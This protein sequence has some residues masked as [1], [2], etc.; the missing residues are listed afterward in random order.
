[1]SFLWP[2]GL[3]FLALI[4]GI[5]L[6]YF[7]RL[8][9][10][11]RV[12]SSTFL[13]KKA[14]D[15]YRVN[16]P[17]QKFQNHLMLWLQLIAVLLLSVAASR[18]YAERR[19]RT[20]GVHIV[21]L[22]H[23]ASM[24]VREEGGVTRL[25]LA[26]SF[27]RDMIGGLRSGERMMVIGFSDRPF[28]AAPLTSDRAV[29]IRGTN[30]VEPTTRP[31]RI[32]EAWHTALSV[33]R[34][35]DLSDIYLLSDGGFRVLPQLTQAHANV[36]YIPF[37]KSWDNVGIVHVET[38]ESEDSERRIEIFARTVNRR[39]QPARTTVEL[40]FGDRLVDAQTIEIPA[41][42]ERGVVFERPAQEEGMAEIRL[43][44]GGAFA[45][46]DRAWIPLGGSDLVRVVLVGEENVFLKQAL[47]MIPRLE[48]TVVAP[49]DFAK[50]RSK[51]G[52]SDLIV[53]DG[54]DAG[55]LER[56]TC[57]FLG[58]APPVPGFGAGKE[59]ENPTL[60][61]WDAEHPLTRYINF[62]TL[63]VGKALQI[64]VPPWGRTLLSSDRGPIISV[65]ERGGL[66]VACVAFRI[67]D[68]D[69]PMR[70]SFP[71]FFANV[72]RWARE[73]DP[74]SA[75]RVVRPGQPLV[76][77]APREPQAGTVQDPSGRARPISAAGADH[78]I[79]ADTERIGVYRVKWEKRASEV[80]YAVSLTDPGE[81]DIRVP[82]RIEMG[83]TPLEAREGS[84]FVRTEFT[85]W[86]AFL[87]L[88]VLMAEWLV[89]QF[90]RGR[91]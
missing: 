43:G 33:A 38:R 82:D 90:H 45:A 2:A 85:P 4:P 19:Q 13:W 36:H 80:L 61:K 88:A 81:S 3:G 23:S 30:S 50:V 40:R 54:P 48:L 71:I 37:G 68:S 18:P 78:A 47:A 66:R 44:E 91:A 16:R 64:T 76:V 84:A 79:V 25:D 6:L 11:V 32:E 39:A 67:L 42:G 41:G 58:G 27:L 60:L 83:G 20:T 35:F 59:F 17:F 65:G 28:V 34:Q 29:L 49:A 15:A 74:G 22:D 21:L 8:K 63:H 77:R 57:L 87:G 7:L 31:T 52:E 55:P 75:E 73:E 72:I 9:R 51:L 70:V 12:V 10:D 53:F 5:L 56:G 89:Y 62:S 1:M 86:L 26:R 14:V 46:D 24:S 69:W